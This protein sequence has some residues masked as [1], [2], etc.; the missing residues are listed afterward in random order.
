MNAIVQI[1]HKNGQPEWAVIPYDEYERLTELAENQEDNRV[2][3][4]AIKSVEAGEELIPSA[5]VN[6]LADGESPLMVWREYRG[7]ALKGLAER[8]G[9]EEACLMRMENGSESGSSEL[10]TSL[11]KILQVDVDDLEN[12]RSN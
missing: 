5:V 9:V 6:R 1:I 2:F 10:M 12:D 3:D 4:A 7:F 8:L 11:A